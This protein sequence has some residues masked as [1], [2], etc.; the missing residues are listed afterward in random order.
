MQITRTSQLHNIIPVAGCPD[1]VAAV[2]DT[3]IPSD[4]TIADVPLILPRQT[5]SCNIAC[6]ENIADEYPDTDALVTRLKNVAIGIRTADCVPILLYAADTKTIGAVHAGWKGT[7]GGILSDTIDLLL[8]AGSNP[9]N[10]HACFCPAICPDC[11][12]VDNDLADKFRAAGFENHITHCRI[13]P[14][15]MKPFENTK[16]H[17]DLIGCN[18]R[19]LIRKGIPMQ[20][21][22]LPLHCTRHSEIENRKAYHS[23]RRTPGTANRNISFIFIPE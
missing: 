11:F 16:P 2:A 1:I 23:W 22:S 4:T 7:L 3:C 8:S 20:N 14:L 13:D 17:I 18:I 12:E 21:I 6:V 19:R 5:H 15:T 10:I 9:E